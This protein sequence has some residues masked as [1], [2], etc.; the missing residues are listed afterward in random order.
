MIAAR[1]ISDNA[2]D[3]RVLAISSELTVGFGKVIDHVL[4]KEFSELK[5]LPRTYIASAIVGAAS[6]IIGESIVACS[7]SEGDVIDLIKYVSD[8]L[9]SY[10]CNLYTMRG[11]AEVSK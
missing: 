1:D 4:S 5:L 8:E 7:C 11:P 10:T 3:K 2:Q 9:R 6:S